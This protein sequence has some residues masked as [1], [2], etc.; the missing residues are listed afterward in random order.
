MSNAEGQVCV[1]IPQLLLDKKR[2]C[3]VCAQLTLPPLQYFCLFVSTHQIGVRTLDLDSLI[4]Y[5]F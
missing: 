5:P 2:R 1:E 3:A 4:P